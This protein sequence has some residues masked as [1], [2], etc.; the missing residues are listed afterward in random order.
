MASVLSNS[1]T[2]DDL[3]PSLKVISAI[4][5]LSSRL[6]IYFNTSYLCPIPSTVLLH[7]KYF[8]VVQGRVASTPS[9]R[10]TRDPLAIAGFLVLQ[11]LRAQ[12]GTGLS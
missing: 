8:K 12:N 2:S 1:T 11:T 9:V 4:L 3:E 6:L 10:R 7:S 5:N